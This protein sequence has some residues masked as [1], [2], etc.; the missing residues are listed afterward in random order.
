MLPPEIANVR[1]GEKIVTKLV[2]L[3]KWLSRQKVIAD[4]RFLITE[5]PFGTQVEF[6]EPPVQVPRRLQIT[7]TG[8]S[9]FKVGYGLIN[10]N[11]PH[12]YN[13]KIGQL[14]TIDPYMQEG[15]TARI[16]EHNQMD[17]VYFFAVVRFISKDKKN[18]PFTVDRVVIEAW[19]ESMLVQNNVA[20]NELSMGVPHNWTGARVTLKGGQGE[21][22]IP[23]AMM[24]YGEVHQVN[25]M[26]LGYRVYLDGE[27]KRMAYWAQ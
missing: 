10:G 8:D 3:I 16:P 9:D 26:D 17:R 24:Q 18:T 7:V 12:F 15:A 5:T 1:P 21:F 25:S 23:L 27:R 14:Q 2:A 22:Y 19:S 4:E 11:V 6:D 20:I 13:Y